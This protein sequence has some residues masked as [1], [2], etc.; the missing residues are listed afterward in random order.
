MTIDQE[1]PTPAPQSARRADSPW[2]TGMLL[3]ANAVVWLA[4]SA[5]GDTRDPQVLVD[6]GAMFGPLIVGGEYWRLFTAMFLHAGLAHLVMNGL[7]LLIVGRLVE[8][9]YGHI[10]FLVVYLLAGL[11][12]SV[13]SFGLNSVAVGAG[14]SGAIFGILG[15]LVAFFVVHRDI[16]GKEGRQSLVGVLMVIGLV[17]ASGIQTEEVDNW[18]HLGGLLAG[19]FIGLAISPHYKPVA[20]AAGAYHVLVNTRSLASRWWVVPVSAVLLVLGTFAASA[21]LPEPAF[22]HTALAESYFAEGDLVKALAE[23]DEAIS[24]EMTAARAYYIRALIRLEQ[25]NVSA[26]RS[27]LADAILYSGDIDRATRIE[28]IRLLVRIGARR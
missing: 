6:F 21:R 1:N 28:A 15:A 24:L 17:L 12:G 9:S 20:V 26:A 11:F 18:A 27:E 14:A 8:K 16:F 10:R 25:G 22:P 3:A 4:A 2:A 5:A 13:A 23:A 7:G 19:F